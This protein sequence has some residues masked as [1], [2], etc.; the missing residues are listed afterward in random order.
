MSIALNERTVCIHLI[1]DELLPLEIVDAILGRS[2][3]NGVTYLF[4]E[5]NIV[6]DTESASSSI[7][8]VDTGSAYE[9]KVEPA[10]IED[11]WSSSQPAHYILLLTNHTI[12]RHGANITCCCANSRVRGSVHECCTGWAGA[13]L[14][15]IT[16]RW[17]RR[18]R[19]SR[20]WRC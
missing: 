13:R 6:A 5:G 9:I 15:Y 1:L 7:F 8:I 18:T 17:K 19:S 12:I 2:L 14:T 20:G 16:T 4:G 3:G 11:C 10:C